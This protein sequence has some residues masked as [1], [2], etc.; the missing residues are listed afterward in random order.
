[1]PRVTIEDLKKIRDANVRTTALRSGEA[2]ARVVVHLGTCGIAAGARTVM[3]AL[4]RE[5]EARGVSDVLVTTT[6]CAGLCSR[7]PMVTVEL[8]G[9]A[10]VKYVELDPDKMRRIFEEHVL[11]GS[12]VQA[13]AL[14]SGSETTG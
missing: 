8:A 4:L 13:Y 12:L 11:G 1:M 3:Q 9:R 6:G 5:I 2:R 7:E 10:P 14:A